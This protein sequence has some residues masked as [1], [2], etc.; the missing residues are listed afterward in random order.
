VTPNGE[1]PLPFAL[2]EAAGLLHGMGLGTKNRQNQT[3]E[4]CRQYLREHHRDKAVL[5]EEF[6][7]EF[8]GARES[9][10]VTRWGKFTDAKRSEKEMLARLEAHFENWL[11]PK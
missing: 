2:S 4:L 7:E 6:I 9:A 11:N 5:V 1:E 8:E 10:D 3:A